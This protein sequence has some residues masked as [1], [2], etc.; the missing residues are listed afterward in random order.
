MT[1][2]NGLKWTYYGDAL[3]A[4][5]AEM[6]FGLAPSVSDA[7]H[8]AVDEALTGYPYPDAEEAVARAASA[9]WLDR[10]G[11]KVE[12]SWVFPAPDVI[13]GTRRAITHLTR[14]GS[15]VVL[16]SPVYFPFY[17]MV[18]RAGRDIIEVPSPRDPDGRY[19]LDLD[20]IDRAL[21]DGAGSIV[22]CN[23]W[24]PTGRV[25]SPEE[26]AD[27]V[28]VARRHDARVISDEIHAA[29]VYEGHTHTPLATLDTDL[30]VTVTSASK[31]WNLPGLKCAQ[32]VLTAERDREKW[33]AFFTPE[34]V[35]VGT[36][37]LIANR[38][39]YDG[40]VDWLDAILRRLGQNRGLLSS[41]VDQHLPL[42]PYHPPEG[43]YLSWLDIGPYGLDDPASF[44][45]D[46]ARVALTGGG[47]FG[48]GVGSFV[49]FNFATSEDLIVA[50]V[51]RMASALADR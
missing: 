26:L 46:E 8:G 22:V 20:A 35:G 3:P 42:V 49:R 9:F 7:L 50:M 32:V 37:G 48:T 33:D 14:P 4:W 15:P 34:K 47:P 51:E 30:V 29:I 24:N 21:D 16:H 17:G 11:W 40:G 12:P 13:E 25:L 31:A 10:F 18:E 27:V 1:S 23:P 36:F 44:F 6:D 41:L 2:R 45:L 43:T 28:D 19:T 5:V 39:A 38:A